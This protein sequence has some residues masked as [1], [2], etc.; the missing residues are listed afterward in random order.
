MQ[1]DLREII[2]GMVL[3]Q[4]RHHGSIPI[5]IDLRSKFG[6]I[7]VWKACSWSIMIVFLFVGEES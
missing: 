5:I 1:F 6:H 4:Y 2:T 7:R 3:L